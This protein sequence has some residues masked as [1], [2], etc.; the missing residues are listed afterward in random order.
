M[1]LALECPSLM[2]VQALEC[3][4][5]YWFGIG[6][7]HSGSLCLGKLLCLPLVKP[8]PMDAWRC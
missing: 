5:L 7:F 3:L 1:I 6:D 2:I 4:Q 8:M